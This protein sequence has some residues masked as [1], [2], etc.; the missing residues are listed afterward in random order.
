[1]GISYYYG[2]TLHTDTLGPSHAPHL[3]VVPL[4]QSLENKIV[5]YEN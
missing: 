3:S 1:M 4:N 5:K 2:F